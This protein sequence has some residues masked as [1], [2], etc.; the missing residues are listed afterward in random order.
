MDEQD[1]LV[2]IGNLG[3][4]APKKSLISSVPIVNLREVVEPKDFRVA[5]RQELHEKLDRLLDEMA[6]KNVL[7]PHY[8]V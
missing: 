7:A 2:C 5:D 1:E 3:I 8:C 6:D 4:Y